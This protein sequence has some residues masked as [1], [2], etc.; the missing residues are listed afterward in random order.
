MRG[1]GKR[2]DV[3][4][5]LR[6]SYKNYMQ[7]CEYRSNDIVRLPCVTAD[8]VGLNV[9]WKAIKDR[10][11][12]GRRWQGPTAFYNMLRMQMAVADR[13]GFSSSLTAAASVV[14]VKLKGLL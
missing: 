11:L 5:N 3:L 8:R 1:G 4:T 9:P 2:P 7:P 6:L 14:Q 10:A 12:L 13:V